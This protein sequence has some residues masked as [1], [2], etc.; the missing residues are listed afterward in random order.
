MKFDR[1]INASELKQ[2]REEIK[3]IVDRCIE[4]KKRIHVLVEAEKKTRSTGA[5]SQSHHLNGHIQQICRETGNDFSTV[6]EFIKSQAIARGYPQKTFHGRP[7]YDLNDRPVGISEAD[8][9]TEQCALL[10][11][12]AHMLASDLGI[13]LME[14]GYERYFNY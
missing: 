14:D 10:I 13:I 3:M 9:T 5:F 8:S 1:I 6:K 2:Y 12:Q 4:D 11:E 7:M